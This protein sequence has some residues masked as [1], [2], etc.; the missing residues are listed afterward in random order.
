M[1]FFRK[2]KQEKRYGLSITGADGKTME[3]WFHDKERR[4]KQAKLIKNR[5]T[6]IAVSVKKIKR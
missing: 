2:E 6:K 4:D 1:S 5:P 3:I